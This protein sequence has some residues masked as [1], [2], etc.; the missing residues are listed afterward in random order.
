MNKEP[1]KQHTIYSDD[2]A[3]V[4]ISHKIGL[5]GGMFDYAVYF[6]AK[7]SMRIGDK[8]VE[9]QF[10]P[11]Q[12]ATTIYTD[13]KPITTGR[14]AGIPNVCDSGYKH[15]GYSTKWEIDEIDVSDYLPIKLDPID[16]KTKVIGVDC[17]LYTE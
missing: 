8:R 3:S 5:H 6:N 1:I 17:H 11:N 9:M 7:A 2:N 10:Y 12:M 15:T 14:F 16:I 13:G 4:C